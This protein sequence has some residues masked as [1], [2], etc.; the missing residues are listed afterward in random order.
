MH[1]SDAIAMV[2]SICKELRQLNS[3]RINSGIPVK[4]IDERPDLENI[5][6]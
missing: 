6:V 4:N 3:I 5:K 2:E 1:P